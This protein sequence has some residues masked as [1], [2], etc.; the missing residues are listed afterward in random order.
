MYFVTKIC[1]MYYISRKIFAV[2]KLQANS[3][4]LDFISHWLLTGDVPTL[5]FHFIP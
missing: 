1:L 4:Y 5:A 3:K 2:F